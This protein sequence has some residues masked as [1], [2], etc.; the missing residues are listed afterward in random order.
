MENNPLH[1]AIY[2]EMISFLSGRIIHDLNNALSSVLGFAELAKL[3]HSQGDNVEKELSDVV[4]AA[5]RARDLAGRISALSHQER[6]PMMPADAVLLIK[7]AVRLIRAML[8][9]SLEIDFQPGEYN[10]LVWTDPLRFQHI[11]MILCI[12]VSQSKKKAPALLQIGLQGIELNAGDVA[13]FAS[14]KPGAHLVVTIGNV[15][16]GPAEDAIREMIAS[17]VQPRTRSSSFPGFSLV[18]DMIS[19][20][21]A[22]VFQG[23]AADGGNFFHLIFPEYSLP[24]R[25]SEGMLLKPASSDAETL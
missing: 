3:G 21:H 25:E 12:A 16:C 11:L 23:G 1:Q 2:K 6:A 17:A 24:D 4:R 15:P 9:A 5:L 14:L 7:D 22:A 8:P 18:Q 20:M 13:S 10:G 19:V